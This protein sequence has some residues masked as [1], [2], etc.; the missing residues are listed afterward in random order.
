MDRV[1]YDLE[2]LSNCFIACFEDYKT[3][4]TK[5][6]VVHDLRNDFKEFVEYIKYIKEKKGWLISFN[7]LSFDS[8]ILE[9]ISQYYDEWK[10]K[11]GCEIAN[12]IY[13]FGQRTI[14]NQDQLPEY[15]E[16]KLSTNNIDVFKLNHWDN[17]AKRS[18]LKW[19]QYSMDWATIQDMPLKHT[20]V[21]KTI[22][23]IDMIIDYCFN[24]VKSTKQIMN[25]SKEQINLRKT[26][27]SEYGINLFSASE[28]R[29]SRELFLYFLSKQ[30]G[31]S[32]YDL[33]QLR[34]F[35]TNIRVKDIILPYIKFKSGDFQRL[36]NQFEKLDINPNETKNAFK[37]SLKYKGVTTDFGLGGVHGAANAG[38]YEANEEMIIMSSD[39]VSFYP[40]LAIRNGWAPAHLPKKEFCNLYEWFFEERKKIPKKDPKNYV[41]KIILNST[42]GLSNDKNS[43]LYD[44]E[45]TMRI[46]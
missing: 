40:N 42:Y 10:D 9:F 29:I 18:S 1:V 28:P 30:T 5:V 44:P 31:I 7:G 41:Y 24:D 27:T 19:I 17:P 20:T 12:I 32:K 37:Y 43:F 45:F 38:I 39:V 13:K 34:T 4:E 15:P 25:L 2:T 36:L 16:W 26:L 22:D 35:R 6:F 14:N 33:K 21:I 46:K 3:E 8:P 11:S 23:E